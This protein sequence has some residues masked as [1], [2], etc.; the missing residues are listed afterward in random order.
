M[1]SSS[2]QTSEI[3][4]P[5]QTHKPPKITQ[6]ISHL[7]LA[8]SPHPSLV[9]LIIPPTESIPLIAQRLRDELDLASEVTPRLHRLARMGAL[10][11]TLQQ[12][13]C[14]Y[15]LPPNGLVV[16]CGEVVGSDGREQRINVQ[17]EPWKEVGEFGYYVDT[18]FHTEAMGAMLA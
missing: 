2:T 14:H 9:S 13:L 6:L 7:D 12:L 1:A 18:R 8:S 16:Y 5:P 4:P 3:T 11:S 17:F 10:T 15:E